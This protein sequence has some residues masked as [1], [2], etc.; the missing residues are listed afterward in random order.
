MWKIFFGLDSRRSF[1]SIS[2]E[3]EK[4]VGTIENW[5]CIIVRLNWLN[6]RG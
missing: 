2:L 6:E 5:N 3:L 4:M 1:D